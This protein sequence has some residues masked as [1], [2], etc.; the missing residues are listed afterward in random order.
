MTSIRFDLTPF[1]C[2]ST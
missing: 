2:D 1:D